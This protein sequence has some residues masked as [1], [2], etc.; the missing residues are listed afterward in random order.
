M[1]HKAKILIVEDKAITAD[2]LKRSLERLGYLVS[3]VVSSGDEAIKKAEEDK[4]DLVLMDIKLQEDKM[5]GIEAASQIRSR[6]NIPVI[7]TTAYTDKETLQQAIKT[8]PYGYITKPFR[9]REIHSNIEIA[10]YKHNAEKT[11]VEQHVKSAVSAI[12]SRNMSHNIGGHI[13]INIEKNISNFKDNDIQYL[14]RYLRGRM[15][16]LVQIFADWPTLSLPVRFLQ[17]LMYRFFQQINILQYIGA[18]E[19]LNY[20]N[21]KFYFHFINGENTITFKPLDKKDCEEI[22][23]QRK[24]FL[25]YDKWLSIVGSTTGLHAFYVILENIIRNAAKH[26]Y[27]DSGNLEIHIRLN[28]NDKSYQVE[29]WD[30]VSIVKKN[31]DKENELDCQIRTK[32]ETPIITDQGKMQKGNWGIT[33]MKIAS[34][35]L[36]KADYRLLGQ[37]GKINYD[38]LKAD[39]ELYNNSYV[40]KYIFHIPK[41][42]EII[43]IDKNGINIRAYEEHSIYL[44]KTIFNSTKIDCEFMVIISPDNKNDKEKVLKEL[45]KDKGKYFEILPTRIFWVGDESDFETINDIP[46]YIPKRI[47]ILKKSEFNK[48]FEN[49]IENFKLWLYMEWI[50]HLRDN[51]RAE[52]IVEGKII[53]DEVIYGKKFYLYLKLTTDDRKEEKPYI[54][55]YLKEY[56]PYFVPPLIED[57][58][59]SNETALNEWSR[60]KNKLSSSKIHDVI[61]D[62]LIHEE[63]PEKKIPI[64]AYPRH[65]AHKDKNLEEIYINDKKRL[66]YTEELSGVSPHFNLL[67]SPPQDH[68]QLQKLALSLIEGGLLRIAIAD[69]R[70]GSEIGK[71]LFDLKIFNLI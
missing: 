31:K 24:E 37:K 68:Y 71:T 54:S 10:L 3:S 29:I 21:L 12:M 63:I 9:E 57:S 2:D 34:A 40:L 66:I 20:N 59:N 42:K 25:K 56:Y 26:S 60:I 69:D 36:Q 18:S 44:E 32:I 4:P 11:I 5:D 27:F 48:E 51:V 45:S 46:P 50:K 1:T 33:E 23:K 35:F 16:F 39:R 61:E 47:H 62:I 8:E 15:Y 49:N 7:Y 64:I 70:I 53:K 58:N 30:N 22:N 14:L 38:I 6:F 43:L 67:T 55:D 17:D 41:P 13:L 52:D 19:K 65:G 28:E